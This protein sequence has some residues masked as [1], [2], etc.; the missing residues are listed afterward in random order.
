MVSSVLFAC[1]SSFSL[2][3]SSKE[4]SKVGT[5]PFKNEGLTGAKNRLIARVR[6]SVLNSTDKGCIRFD[7]SNFLWAQF[8]YAI[9]WLLIHGMCCG[10]FLC[11]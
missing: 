6:K 10:T 4:R 8:G 11:A 3:K 9:H 1:A 7:W 5:W 2:Y